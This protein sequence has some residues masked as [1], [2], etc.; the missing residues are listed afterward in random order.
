MLCLDVSSACAF[1]RATFALNLWL[2][3]LLTVIDPQRVLISLTS[4][5][6]ASSF[7]NYLEAIRK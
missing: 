6:I 1:F 3:S 5:F 2:Q 4:S 7:R